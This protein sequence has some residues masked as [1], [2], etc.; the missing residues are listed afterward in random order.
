MGFG[1]SYLQEPSHGLIE[2]NE[3]ILGVAR[4]CISRISCLFGT[5]SCSDVD[6]LTKARQGDFAFQEY[7]VLQ[8]LHHLLG[9][10]SNTIQFSSEETANLLG[11][12]SK[13][14]ED[15]K[16]SSHDAIDE[17]PEPE[18][19]CAAENSILQLVWE[20][21]KFQESVQLVPT[22]L[23]PNSTSWNNLVI[24]Q[25]LEPMTKDI[26]MLA[27]Y[28]SA[29]ENAFEERRANRGLL[30]SAYGEL[31]FRCCVLACRRFH[32]G[33]R[34]R[35]LRDDHSKSH[36]RAFKCEQS[37]CDSAVLGFPSQRALDLHFSLCHEKDAKEPDFPKI[38]PRSLWKSLEEAIDQ[39]D[40]DAVRPL[41][42]EAQAIDDRPRGFVARALKKRNL[43]A[44]EILLNHIGDGAELAVMEKNGHN[45]LYCAAE[46]GY[47]DFFERLISLDVSKEYRDP[48]GA[49]GV[50]NPLTL[51][52][53][54]GHINIVRVILRY[55]DSDARSTYSRN[56]LEAAMRNGKEDVAL[57]LCEN[58][59]KRGAQLDVLK[60]SIRYRL[61]SCVKMMLE[62]CGTPTNPRWAH[63]APMVVSDIDKAVGMCMEMEQHSLEV[64][65]RSAIRKGNVVEAEILL[66][67]GANIN[68]SR[69]GVGTPLYAAV[70][71][72]HEPVVRF[73]LERGA[74][75]N[76]DSGNAHL[77][78]ALARNSIPM[79]RILI[80]Y[81]ATVNDYSVNRSSVLCDASERGQEEAVQLLLQ[82]GAKVDNERSDHKTA[83]TLALEKGHL[84]VLRLL[85]EH[86]AN[87]NGVSNK[88]DIPLY[89][90]SKNGD[91]GVLRLLLEAGANADAQVEKG[92]MAGDTPLRVASLNNHEA[93]ASTLVARGADV[94]LSGE[95]VPS[96]LFSA[97][98]YG[99]DKIVLLLLEAGAHVDVGIHPGSIHACT[100]LQAASLG[101][102]EI[103]V[104]MLIERGADVNTYSQSYPSALYSA[105]LRG[106]ESVVE[107]LLEAG[108]DAEIPVFDQHGISLTPLDVALRNGHERTAQLL[109]EARWS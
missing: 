86:G 39:N 73:L 40:C 22:A 9:L 37:T 78:V 23:M 48:L 75:V 101:G 80:E 1:D 11:L 17:R 26:Y 49:P 76:R 16:K 52:A 50:S 57:L 66:D 79:L 89:M 84:G 62:R 31:P 19:I 38:R 4:L 88:S 44:A 71:A 102:H 53:K 98:A 59:L 90:A 43:E 54:N 5:A 3:A 85:L 20:T 21:Q 108:A 67:R 95:K 18:T 33:F 68:D 27:R 81:G 42:I 7:P 70:H 60:K 87:V 51:A 45:A 36:D 46:Q 58:V 94:N 41:C 24:D 55:L 35:R 97:S 10:Q 32:H 100:P 105:S 56:A 99:N 63:I 14:L 82:N 83:L 8:W 64:Q 104:R 91:L 72:G 106:Y 6:L 47:V 92:D 93:V 65:L 96:A 25:S 2:Y 109:Q 74:D 77:V 69:S 34:T 13:L 30:V 107:M 29:I 28:R 15:Y 12:A 61:K 103:T